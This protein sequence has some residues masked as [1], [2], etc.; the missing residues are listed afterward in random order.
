MAVTTVKETGAMASE[1]GKPRHPALER[2]FDLLEQLETE[3]LKRR[4]LAAQV[5][6]DLLTEAE[7]VV[8]LDVYGEFGR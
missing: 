6:D 1:R 2:A 7:L 8:I 5:Q 4:I 3:L